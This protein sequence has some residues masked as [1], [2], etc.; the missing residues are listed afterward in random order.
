MAVATVTSKGQVT[1]PKEVRDE[2][3]IETGTKLYFVRSAQG[4]ILKPARNSILALAGTVQYEGPALS[5][6]E[7][8]DAIGLAVAEGNDQIPEQGR[9]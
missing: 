8:D 9:K 5:I 4:Y 6:E 1:I 3:G 2:L 7:M